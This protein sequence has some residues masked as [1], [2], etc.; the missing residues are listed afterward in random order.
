MRVVIDT[1]ILLLLHFSDV[2][3]PINPKTGAPLDHAQ[4]RV[5]SLIQQ[6]SKERAKVLVPSP[7]LSEFLVH[8]GDRTD[9]YVRLFQQPPFQI[10]QFAARAA[11][12]CANAIRR[13]GMKG[14]ARGAGWRHKVKFDRQIVSIAVAE[15]ADRIYSDDSDI[16]Q[17]GKQVGLSVVTSFDLEIA[18]ELRQCKLD[19]KPAESD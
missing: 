4:E 19:L 10:A 2:R 14:S 8:G 9:E 13:F 17:Y 7:V 3:A 6:L 15:G 16:L 11:I 1:N 5:E 12:E 18:P